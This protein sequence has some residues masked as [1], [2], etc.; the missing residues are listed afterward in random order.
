MP[1]PFESSE[2][3]DEEYEASVA[4]SDEA[5]STSTGP[6]VAPSQA[7]SLNQETNNLSPTKKLDHQLE[8][9]SAEIEALKQKK[10][11]L[12]FEKTQLEESRRRR[13]ELLNGHR[14]ILGHLERATALF[15]KQ[16]T[17]A[18]RRAEQLERSF[19][20]LT[21]A[22]ESVKKVQPDQWTA[23]QWTADLARGLAT[24]DNAR[25]EWHACQKKWPELTQA[26]NTGDENASLPAQKQSST[27]PENNFWN[28]VKIGMAVTLPI[29]VTGLIALI[30]SV[31]LFYQ[32]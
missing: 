12:E 8:D 32:S 31:I 7:S 9:A 21:E 27:V 29:T 17:E 4:A 11:A 25:M 1:N 5:T 28:W 10:A 13:H 30:V 16:A 23:D 2:F 6:T 22:L 3:V 26:P 24:V 18:R 14:E 15:E 19:D 20:G